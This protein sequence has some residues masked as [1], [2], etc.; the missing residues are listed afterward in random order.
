MPLMRVSFQEKMSRGI[1]RLLRGAGPKSGR[2]VHAADHEPTSSGRCHRQHVFELRGPD[3]Y[4]PI[5]AKRGGAANG[6]EQ[7]ER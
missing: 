4:G 2:W 1:E 6:C 7:G 3:A 5:L